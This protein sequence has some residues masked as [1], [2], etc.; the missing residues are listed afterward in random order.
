MIGAAVLSRVW[1]CC[2]IGE[3]YVSWTYLGYAE[4]TLCSGHDT[5]EQ[6]GRSTEL[7]PGS[8]G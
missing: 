2:R 3:C 1:R 5:P 6:F 7:S 4:C 8:A